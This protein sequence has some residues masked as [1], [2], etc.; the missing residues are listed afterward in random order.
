MRILLLD[1]VGLV[2]CGEADRER[3]QSAEQQLAIAN[4]EIAKLH[5]RADDQ[6][7]R[8]K[9]ATADAMACSETEMVRHMRKRVE[10]NPYGFAANMGMK[11]TEILDER[12]HLRDPTAFARRLKAWAA[13]NRGDSLS[14][15][16]QTFGSEV[17]SA[18]Y[19]DRIR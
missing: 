12:G 10:A 1:L 4:I 2:G 15:L 17:G 16:V 7:V 19:Y 11:L 9:Q 5:A 13:R 6:A 3:V 8:L 14:S 18:I